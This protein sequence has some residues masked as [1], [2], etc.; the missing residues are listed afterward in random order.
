M[1]RLRS[2][3]GLGLTEVM[4]AM[5][6]LMIVLMAML[7][8]IV[9]SFRALGKNATQATAT[10]LATARIEYLQTIAVQGLC[11]NFVSTG[12]QTE[13]FTDGRG[14]QLTVSGTVSGC[15]QVGDPKLD[16]KLASVTIEVTSDQPGYP[17]PLVE[18]STTIYVRFAPS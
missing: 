6:V 14:V 12:E 3:D 2:D 15:E 17:D 7:T 11:T 9:A 8:V 4:V 10:E 18:R 16:P 5:L 1:K 13:T